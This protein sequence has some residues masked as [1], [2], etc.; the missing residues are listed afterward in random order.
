M[1]HPD[2]DLT[3]S[4]GTNDE[5]YFAE[6]VHQLLDTFAIEGTTLIDGLH[7]AYPVTERCGMNT[8]GTDQV[9]L[10][11]R[12]MPVFSTYDS[13]HYSP[14]EAYYVIH[15]EYSNLPDDN[16][17]EGPIM[18]ED[19]TWEPYV[20]AVINTEDHGD[21]SVL[22][23]RTGKSLSSNDLRF[24]LSVVSIMRK[25]FR[26]MKFEED[27]LDLQVKPA[28]ESILE[29]LKGSEGPLMLKEFVS[30]DFLD[31][32]ECDSCSTHNQPCEH[33]PHSLS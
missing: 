31:V 11:L 16:L 30:T 22:N 7:V 14:S 12:G 3:V 18:D 9:A 25:E 17:T 5:R 21:I 2:F 28:Y 27:L 6:E 26:G 8:F 24:A 15:L 32:S 29:K 13:R 4:A 19:L 33:N 1:E 10:R 23:A 20:V